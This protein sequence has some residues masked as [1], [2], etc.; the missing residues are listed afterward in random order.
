MVFKVQ[1]LPPHIR[2]YAFTMSGILGT[3]RVNQNK[4]PANTLF[5]FV[6][7]LHL[8]HACWGE[9]RDEPSESWHF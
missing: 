3:V 1:V 7:Q 9:M 2:R 6:T 8:P 4:P 5:G